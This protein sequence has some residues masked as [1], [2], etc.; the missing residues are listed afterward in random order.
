MLLDPRIIQFL[1]IVTKRMLIYK[2]EAKNFFKSM[3]VRR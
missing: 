2:N 3:M 1:W